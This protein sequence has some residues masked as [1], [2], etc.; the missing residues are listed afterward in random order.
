LFASV[1]QSKSVEGIPRGGKGF[2]I[3]Y[4][5]NREREAG[6]DAINMLTEVRKFFLGVYMPIAAS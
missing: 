1:L 2:I 3:S 6:K 4:E 5:G